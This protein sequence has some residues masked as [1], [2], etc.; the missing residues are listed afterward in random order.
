MLFR[1]LATIVVLLLAQIPQRA[2]ERWHIV[3]YGILGVLWWAALPVGG[4]RRGIAAAALAGGAGWLDEGVQYFL[5]DRVYD[6]WDVLLNAVSG[7]AGVAGAEITVRIPSRATMT[8]S[9]A[10]RG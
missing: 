4:W 8:S 5:P 3:Q 2:E 7:V 9:G 6:L 1:S 10:N